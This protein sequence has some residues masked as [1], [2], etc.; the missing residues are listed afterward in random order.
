MIVQTDTKIGMGGGILIAIVDTAISFDG[1]AEFGVKALIGAMA[2]LIA[3]HVIYEPTKKL[4]VRIFKFLKI[5]IKETIKAGKDGELDLDDLPG[6][7]KLYIQELEAKVKKFEDNSTTS[8][9][10]RLE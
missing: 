6:E 10:L 5:K 2:G 8:D 4:I 7:M 9:K 3:K 1:L